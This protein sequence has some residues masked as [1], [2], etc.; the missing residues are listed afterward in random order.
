MGH[1]YGAAILGAGGV[2]GE[3]VKAFRDHPLIEIVGIYN[4]TPGKATRLLKESLAT[5]G[6]DAV[7]ELFPG[8]NH[9][10]IDPKLR[11]RMNK[12]MA[13]AVGKSLPD[14]RT[15]GSCSS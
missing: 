8:K 6:S 15:I 2:A 9:G 13:E 10:L 4:R 11:E 7:V 1:K 14:E 12:E 5:L 3:Y